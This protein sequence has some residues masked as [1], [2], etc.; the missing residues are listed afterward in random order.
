MK[1]TLELAEKIIDAFSS[2]NVALVSDTIVHGVDV[3]LNEGEF[4]IRICVADNNQERIRSLKSLPAFK[5]EAALEKQTLILPVFFEQVPMARAQFAPGD[6]ISPA[7]ASYHGT[8]GWNFYLNDRPMILSNWHVLCDQ[9]NQTPIGRRILVNGADIASLHAFLHVNSGR[10]NDWDY[11]LARFDSEA[12]L[13]AFMRRCVSECPPG[14]DHC[15]IPIEDV[16]QRIIGEIVIGLRC[17]KI[18]ARPPVCRF[19]NVQAFGTRRV[20]YGQ[21]GIIEFRNQVIFSKM[22]DPGD[23]GSVL[24]TVQNGISLAVALNFAGSDQETIANPLTRAPLTYLGART[25]PGTSW[26]VPSF[27]GAGL[28]LDD[29]T[30][31]VENADDSTQ[32]ES[33]T[34]KIP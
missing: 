4:S 16:P 26:T 22:S 33:K 7:G 21:A 12:S 5:F 10:Q 24:F 28:A 25:I 14:S 20:N 18:G 29:T 31:T 15:T 17:K 3:V 8:G 27:S 1:M 19:G 6:P 34:E 11:A 32:L 9:G 23:S 2:Q 13:S 30:A